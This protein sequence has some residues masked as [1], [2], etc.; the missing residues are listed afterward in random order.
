MEIYSKGTNKFNYQMNIEDFHQNI[1][2]DVKTELVDEFD[3]NF[4]RKAFFDQAWPKTSLI[5]R[6]GSMMAR[7]NNL[8]RGYQAKIIGEKIAFTNS[9]PY[10]SLHNEGGEITVTKKMKSYF[11]AMYYQ[12]SGGI[13]YN[14]K[15]KAAAKTKKN[16]SL[17]IEAQ[18]FKALALMPI[19]KKIKIPSRRVIGKHPRVDEIVSNVVH[20]NL[21]DLNNIIIKI[22]KP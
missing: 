4:E 2:K 10:A 3:R 18:Q 7:T 5:N 9:M 20:E 6:R 19:G 22:L 8:R 11:W 14:I 15:T 13:L 1:I 17:S 12:A 16:I 21:K